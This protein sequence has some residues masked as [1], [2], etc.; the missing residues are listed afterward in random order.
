ML[1][2]DLLPHGRGRFKLCLRPSYFLL[3][4]SD[5]KLLAVVRVTPVK[6][7]RVGMGLF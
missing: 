5:C 6:A 7:I 1:A 4:L 3:Q 2:I